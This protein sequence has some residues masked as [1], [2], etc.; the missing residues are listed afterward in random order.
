ML[1]Q[2]CSFDDVCNLSVDVILRFKWCRFLI[3]HD[4]YSVVAV[5][6]L[7]L[8][9]IAYITCSRTPNHYVIYINTYTT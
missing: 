7:V 9:K 2:M 4:T 1:I 6:Y 3:L 5:S 8:R